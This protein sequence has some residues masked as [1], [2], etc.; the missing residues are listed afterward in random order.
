[1]KRKIIKFAVS[2]TVQVERFEPVTVT[3]EAS[4]EIE[5]GDDVSACEFELYKEVTQRVKKCVDNEVKKYGA[6]KAKREKEE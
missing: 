2:R 6:E 1:M 3:F 4:A 5:P